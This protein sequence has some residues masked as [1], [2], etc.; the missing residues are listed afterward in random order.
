MEVDLSDSEEEKEPINYNIIAI[1]K[2][3]TYEC[4]MTIKELQAYKPTHPEYL[5]EIEKL[6]E[7]EKST[8][9]ITFRNFWSRNNI[10]VHHDSDDEFENEFENEFEDEFDIKSEHEIDF[11][12]DIIHFVDESKEKI[13]IIYIDKSTTPDTIY[14]DEYS[15]EDIQGTCGIFSGSGY[16]YFFKMFEN[17]ESVVNT[18]E[19]DKNNWLDIHFLIKFENIDI[20]ERFNITLFK[21][22]EDESSDDSCQASENSD[23]YFNITETKEYIEEKEDF[24]GG[25]LLNGDEAIALQN[26]ALEA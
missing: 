18:Y 19:F 13:T 3:K 4:D 22:D 10:K 11:D 1:N 8:D 26:L 7:K 14:K 20:E 24:H 21:A 23:G 9:K 12:T 2:V 15:K 16:K 5:K 25:W 6:N 17:L